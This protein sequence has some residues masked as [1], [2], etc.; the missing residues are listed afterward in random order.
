LV[1]VAAR[2]APGNPKTTNGQVLVHN[3]HFPVNI[4]HRVRAEA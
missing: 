1:A 2:V 3:L 4:S